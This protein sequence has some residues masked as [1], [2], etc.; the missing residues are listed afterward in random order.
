MQEIIGKREPA[1][2][3]KVA[4]DKR[5]IDIEKSKQVNDVQPGITKYPWKKNNNFQSAVY[6]THNKK[7]RTWKTRSP[8]FARKQTEEECRKMSTACFKACSVSVST[9]HKMN[10]VYGIRT[11]SILYLI[12]NYS[13]RG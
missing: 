12:D 10:K 8:H 9:L 7:K 11:P 6:R 3:L 13:Y 4:T 5:A 1:T 2:L